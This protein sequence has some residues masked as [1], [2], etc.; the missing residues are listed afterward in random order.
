MHTLQCVILKLLRAS[1]TRNVGAVVSK[2]RE[3]LA[4]RSCYF[5]MKHPWQC[6][7]HETDSICSKNRS[8][9]LSYQAGKNWKSRCTNIDSEIWSRKRMK[10]ARTVSVSTWFLFHLKN[11]I[12]TR[13]SG[14]TVV[15]VDIRGWIG[16]QK[17]T[18]FD[19]HLLLSRKTF[20]TAYI[21]AMHTLWNI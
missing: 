18:N 16:L 13:Y 12:C 14:C 7:I 3:R 9:M 15:D 4:S 1:I 8:W 11:V 21:N 20:H 10:Y 5:I 17:S 2:K 19:I 6:F